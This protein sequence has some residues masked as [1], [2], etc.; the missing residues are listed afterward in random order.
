MVVTRTLIAILAA[1]AI[2]APTVAEAGK[3]SKRSTTICSS[4]KFIT[5]TVK[6]TCRTR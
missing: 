1:L 4:Y 2:L 6:T 3:Y 5:G